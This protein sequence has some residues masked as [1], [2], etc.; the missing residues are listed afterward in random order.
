MSGRRPYGRRRPQQQQREQYQSH[1]QWRQVEENSPAEAEALSAEEMSKVIPAI[2]EEQSESD[3]V[4]QRSDRSEGPPAGSLAAEAIDLAERLERLAAL[5]EVQAQRQSSADVEKCTVGTNTD[6]DGAS[7]HE[8]EESRTELAAL[9]ASAAELEEELAAAHYRHASVEQEVLSELSAQ[10]ELAEE[11]ADAEARTDAMQASSAS[12]NEANAAAQA[13]IASATRAVQEELEALRSESLLAAAAD[14]AEEATL[15]QELS[16]LEERTRRGAAEVTELGLTPKA[17]AKRRAEVEEATRNAKEAEAQAES[18]EEACAK[19]REEVDSMRFYLKDR[20]GFNHKRTQE[21]NAQIQRLE[22]QR[23]KL[24]AEQAER[25]SKSKGTTDLAE[26][27]EK[28][29]EVYG[30]CL[31]QVQEATQDRDEKLAEV[32]R[33]E[34]EIEALNSE[35]EV[36][37]EQIGQTEA[38]LEKTAIQHRELSLQ[39]GPKLKAEIN[40]KLKQEKIMEQH[41]EQMVLHLEE[42]E[43]A[44]CRA[45]EEEALAEKRLEYVEFNLRVLSAEPGKAKPSRRLRQ[46]SSREVAR[47]GDVV[48]SDSAAGG[49][50][51][52]DE[53]ASSKSSPRESQR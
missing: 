48:S 31:L 27:L 8:A 47:L 36:H 4:G 50:A 16:E 18:L 1:G 38:E 51:T 5:A 49:G 45:E 37:Q 15:R 23:K 10:R 9:R 22:K 33:H 44:A 2:P 43:A 13:L 21:L 30:R 14:E 6:V 11:A 39:Q 28:L 20:R 34:Q 12:K 24:E 42:A 46:R 32:A 17:A 3:A 26:Q 40:E 19:L 35:A 41:N 52:G 53:A 25:A 7:F 29:N